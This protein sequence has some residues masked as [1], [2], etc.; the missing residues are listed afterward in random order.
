MSEDTT[1]F[2]KLHK[3]FPDLEKLIMERKYIVLEPK[4]KLI[5]ANALTKNF[6]YNHIFYKCPYD[7]SLYINLNGKV[8][9]YEHPKFTSYLGWKNDKE[10]ILTI[11]DSYNSMSS[12][13]TCFQLDNVCDEINYTE[14]K[15][16]LKNNQ[17][18]KKS[19]MRQYIEY[20]EELL[21]NDQ[22]KKAYQR[23]TKF[24]KEMKN[25][26]MFMK[27]YEDSYSSI[28]N[29]RF[30]KLVT[31]FTEVLRNPKD[32]YNTIFSIANELVDSLVFNDLYGYLFT[33]CLV[34]FNEEDEK[35]VKMKLKDF[36][37]KYEWEGLGVKEIYHQCKFLSA[38]QFLDN[39]SNYHTIFEKMDVLTNVNTLITEEAKNI[40]E[41]N[42]KGNF[43]PQGDLL[44]TFW[45]YVVAHCNTKNIIAES[46]FINFFGLNGY[47][48]SN[49]VATTFITAVDTIKLESLQNEKIILSQYVEPNKIE[50]P[51]K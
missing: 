45:T 16:I 28:F 32:E 44:L 26:Y 20:N 3:S 47:N 49:Y 14:T 8:L 33:K 9:K 24:T 12:D 11:K 5:A 30:N 18:Q 2:G 27:G 40:Y 29:K 21:K 50:L 39:I 15:S 51:S 10:M 7:P 17:L 31:K 43:I 38:I 48:A 4:K 35:K 1:F 46:Q 13:I 25:N 23:L 41:S 34:K 37:S 36:N 6:Y 19:N 22:Y 42:T